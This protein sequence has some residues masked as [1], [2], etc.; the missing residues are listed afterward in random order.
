[1]IVFQGKCL[2][3]GEQEKINK[4]VF[5]L[6]SWGCVD[7]SLQFDM[8]EETVCMKA[9]YMLQAVYDKGNLFF[10]SSDKTNRNY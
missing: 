9:S 4:Q 7:R 10:V 6:S 8:R 2:F 1:M 3:E 5:E